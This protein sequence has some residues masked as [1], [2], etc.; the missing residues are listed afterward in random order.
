[1]AY[2]ST[3]IKKTEKTAIQLKEVLFQLALHVIVFLFF[4]FD[5]DNPAIKMHQIVFFVTYASGA[6][7]INY[8]LLPRF[9]YQKRYLPFFFYV[10]LI[11]GGLIFMEECVL[12]QIYFP[13]T[14]GK[15][16]PGV[17]YTLLDILPLIAILIGFKFAWD[18]LGKQR[19]VEALRTTVKEGELQFL[20][21]QINPHFLF[22]NLNNLYSYAIEN[23]PK[24][25]QIILELSGVLRYMLYECKEKFVPLAKE[26]KQL[27]NFINLNEMQI[28]E[29]GEVRFSSQGN[30][31]DYQIAPLI[32]IVFIENAFKYST[33]SQAADILIDI[34]IDL[35]EEGVLFFKCV[36]SFQAQSNVDKLSHGIG[37]KNVKKR[38]HLLYPDAHQLDISARD[39]IYE[40]H[41]SMSLSKQRA[42]VSTADSPA[43]SLN[44]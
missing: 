2:L 28:E 38:L 11:L 10:A 14:R 8:L 18:A 9:Y 13:D 22:N 35:S 16:F 44:N 6:F 17:F 27:K 15:K 25:P 4:S 36:N 23:S 3:V 29:R 41:L 5:S 43:V 42:I 7:L 26:V 40:V 32:L 37:L 24:T 34:R 30:V 39:G 1:M 12:E 20:K 21:S 31:A 33:A 19:E